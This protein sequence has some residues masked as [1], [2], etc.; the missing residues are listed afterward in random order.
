VRGIYLG[1]YVRWDPKAQHDLMIE[2]YDFKTA[3][4]ARTFDCYD[5][6]DCNVYMHLHDTLK[7]VKH[8]YGKVVDQTSREIRHK[9]ISRDT[10]LSLINYFLNQ[11]MEYSKYFEEWLGIHEGGIKFFLDSFNNNNK[12]FDKSSDHFPKELSSGLHFKVNPSL[13]NR[14]EFV[15]FGKGF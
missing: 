4:F 15:I 8:G 2:L 5:H 11:K 14:K 12:L 1:N 10:G 3:S 9:R 13:N 7:M 6:V